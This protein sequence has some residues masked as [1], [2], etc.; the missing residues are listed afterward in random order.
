MA[1]IGMSDRM[2]SGSIEATNPREAAA[3]GAGIQPSARRPGRWS[4]RPFIRWFSPD[5][6]VFLFFTEQDESRYKHVGP[7]AA[8]VC[9]RGSFASA[10]L[11]EAGS[12][13]DFLPLLVFCVFGLREP[14]FD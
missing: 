8:K 13:Q 1:V 9:L 7:N 5:G 14:L 12:P 10:T 2:D 3:S 4:P 6:D 11:G